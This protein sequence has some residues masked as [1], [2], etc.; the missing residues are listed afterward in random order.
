[1]SNVQ[2]RHYRAADYPSMPWRNGGGITHEVACETCD[3]DAGFDWRI[4]IAEVAQDGAF[5]HFGGLQRIIAV[6]EGTGMALTFNGRSPDVVLHPHQP[7]AFSGNDQVHCRLLDGPI[8]DL[9]LMYAPTR[10]RAR[11]RWMTSPADLRFHSDASKVL[12][13]NT[14]T[15]PMSCR[16]DGQDHPLPIRYDCLRIDTA[17]TQIECACSPDTASACI[18]ELYLLCTTELAPQGYR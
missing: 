2:V 13:L 12:I 1:M 4:S 15:A 5:S 11:L 14:G 3:G 10:Y 8:R 6:L 16:I 9:N 18:I 17:G 7:F